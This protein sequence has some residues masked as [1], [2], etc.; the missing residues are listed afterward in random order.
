MGRGL[1]FQARDL[2]RSAFTAANP[3]N[4]GGKKERRKA[5]KEMWIS[6]VHTGNLPQEDR[7]SSAWI[8]LVP[9]GMGPSSEFTSPSSQEDSAATMFIFRPPPTIGLQRKVTLVQP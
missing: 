7:R 2:V 1:Q 6:R 4:D 8:H 3:K 9:P 5:D